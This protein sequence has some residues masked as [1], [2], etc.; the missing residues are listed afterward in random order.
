MGIRKQDLI[1]VSLTMRGT[2]KEDLVVI[3]GVVVD[4]TIKD[5]S[6]SNRSTWQLS[7]VSDKMEKA[8]FSSPW[9]SSHLTSLL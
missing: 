9:E 2:I 1:P 6:G 5:P 3:G 8:F 7:Y 4:V